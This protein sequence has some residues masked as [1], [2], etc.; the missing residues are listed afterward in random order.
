MSET[1]S[2]IIYMTATDS[3]GFLLPR[4]PE[5]AERYDRMQKTAA[6][7]ALEGIEVN[8]DTIPEANALIRGDI[9]VEEAIDRI[10]KQYGIS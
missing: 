4:T 3:N 1:G 9:T 6:N 2:K 5:E 10:K 7:F 8:A